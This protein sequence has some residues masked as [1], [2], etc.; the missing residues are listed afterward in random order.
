MDR[1]TLFRY[2]PADSAI[3]RTDPRIKGIALFL[4]CIL[5][6][7]MSLSGGIILLA[8]SLLALAV[9]KI[10]L[11]SIILLFWP[12]SILFGAILLVQLGNIMEGIVLIFR[13]VLLILLGHL[14]TATTTMEETRKSISWLLKPLPRQAGFVISTMLSI[15]LAFIPLLF[16]QA[17][18]I[19]EAQQARNINASMNPLRKIKYFAVQIIITSMEKGEHIGDAME[20]RCYSRERTIH[21]PPVRPDSW[22]FL[23]LSAA[24]AAAALLVPYTFELYI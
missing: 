5:V 1:V 8:S 9:S 7:R 17:R 15:T 11:R 13:I 14:Y 24:A 2:F 22:L 3:H 10:P 19:R 18:E 16:S 21:F 12:F 4:F 20:S 6:F 23:F